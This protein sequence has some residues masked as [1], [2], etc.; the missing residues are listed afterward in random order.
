VVANRFL[1]HMVRYMVGTMVDVARGRRPPDDIDALLRGQTGVTTS[2]PAPAAGLYL[3]RVLYDAALSN[4]T[5]EEWSAG[6][7]ADEILS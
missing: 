3:T 2:P 1:H 5:N 4:E 7:A 6:D